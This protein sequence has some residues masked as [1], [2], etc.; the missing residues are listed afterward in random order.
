MIYP[1][2]Q[3]LARECDY[4]RRQCL[5]LRWT[6][7]LNNDLIRLK[8]IQ[9]RQPFSTTCVRQ[10]DD[11]FLFRTWTFLLTATICVC[12]TILWNRKN[13]TF[14]DVVKNKHYNRIRVSMGNLV[15][16]LN[17]YIYVFTKTCSEVRNAR[18]LC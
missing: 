4:K 18:I 17:I 5:D 8:V 11:I 12:Y 3:K 10:L 9:P 7:D 2:L 16:I 13:V 6:R 1:P 14:A 15:V